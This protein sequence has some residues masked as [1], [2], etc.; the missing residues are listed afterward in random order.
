MDQCFFLQTSG[1]WVEGVRCRCAMRAERLIFMRL[2]ARPLYTQLPHAVGAAYHMKLLSSSST[3]CNTTKMSRGDDGC[4]CAVVYFGEG[5]ASEGYFHAAC[6]FAATLRAPVVFFCRN[7]GYAIS[8]PVTS[9]YSNDA[10]GII[11]RAAP[12]YGIPGIRVDGN[13]VF[14]VH[15]AML[16][17]KELAL[18][19][20]TPVMIEAMTYRMSHH[21]TSDDS[22]RYRDASEV[23]RWKEEFDPIVRLRNFMVRQGYVDGDDGDSTFTVGKEFTARIGEEEH[24]AVMDAMK[25]AEQ[26]KKPSLNTMFEDVYGVKLDHMHLIRQEENMRAHLKKYPEYYNTSMD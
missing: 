25:K 8:T 16:A 14:A 3:L 12:G 17:A 11:G 4:G 26:K 9:Q 5:A 23:V 15:A 7:N 18:R 22:S 19:E 1:I 6:N 24:M 20:N 21:S 10:D 2:A 13:D